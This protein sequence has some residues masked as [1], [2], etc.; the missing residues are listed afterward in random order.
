MRI[1]GNSGDR[2]RVLVIEAGLYLEGVPEARTAL[3]I[4]ESNVA[5]AFSEYS[6][7]TIGDSGLIDVAITLTKTEKDRGVG[8]NGLDGGINHVI[9]VT[10]S[11]GGSISRLSN[12]I[13]LEF[14]PDP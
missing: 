2:V 5:T 10:E 8:P 9:A 6:G 13:V 14:F 4:F 1:Y 11:S 12:M 3:E 7:F